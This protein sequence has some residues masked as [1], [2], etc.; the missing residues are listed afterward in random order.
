MQ[1]A[2]TRT[3][4]DTHTH[5]HIHTHSNLRATHRGHLHTEHSAKCAVHTD[6]VGGAHVCMCMCVCVCVWCVCMCVC[7]PYLN[8]N[9]CT[10]LVLDSEQIELCAHACTHTHAHTHTPASLPMNS[11]NLL[12]STSPS[13]PLSSRFPGAWAFY[14]CVYEGHAF[15]CVNM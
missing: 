7:L 9:K 13:C 3:C 14:E 8:P 10:A 15:V 6:E 12:S 1:H 5:T 4:T 11:S 2:H